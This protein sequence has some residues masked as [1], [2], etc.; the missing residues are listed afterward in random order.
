MGKQAF[1]IRLDENM[2]SR[3]GQFLSSPTHGYASLDE[4]VQVA[5]QNQL[6]I[7]EGDLEASESSVTR[8][9]EKAAS[10]ALVA[11]FTMQVNEGKAF[12]PMLALG[13]ATTQEALAV[14]TDAGWRLATARSPLLDGVEGLTLSAEEAEILRRQVLRA[15]GELEAVRE[16]LQI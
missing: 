14:L 12:G 4:L 2:A 3:L 8:N 7:E 10:S 11:S 15:P 1:V 6:G 5:L 16:F 13:L 9:A